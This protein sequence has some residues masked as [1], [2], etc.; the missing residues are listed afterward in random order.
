LLG[1]LTGEF[2]I[3]IMGM[4]PGVQPMDLPEHAK[5]LATLLQSIHTA[6]A[7]EARDEESAKG[8][9]GKVNAGAKQRGF[10][11]VNVP[12]EGFEAFS[13]AKTIV[14]KR[15]GKPVRTHRGGPALTV[16]HTYSMMRQGRVLIL[17]TG[18]GELRRFVDVKAGRAI[19]LG[20]AASDAHM[21]AALKES[22][23]ALSA[24]LM[25]TRITRELADKGVPPFF[26]TVINSIR[27]VAATCGVHG[28][29]LEVVVEARQ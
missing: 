7:F 1:S 10:V 23:Y 22:R 5:S 29:N 8:L 25:S 14:V 28:D 15:R 6:W 27:E 3:A 13:M 21:K 20:S 26:L 16:T 19:S 18:K 4:D 24:T 11:T 12:V 2:A 17:L 9:F